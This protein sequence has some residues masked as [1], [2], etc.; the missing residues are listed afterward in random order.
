MTTDPH[1]SKRACIIGMFVLRPASVAWKEIDIQSSMYSD[2]LDW[3]YNLRGIDGGWLVANGSAVDAYRLAMQYALSD[4]VIM[5]SNNVSSEGVTVTAKDGT[6]KQGHLWQPYYPC[7]WGHLASSD[8][9]LLCR[10]EEQRC[11]WQKLGYLSDRKYPAQ[12]IFTVSGRKYPSAHDFL[13]ASI[14]T[15]RHPDGS[16]IEV[17]ILTSQ[18]G[19]IEIEQ[20]IMES[21]PHLACRIEKMLISI[22]PPHQDSSGTFLDECPPSDCSVLNSS[23][24]DLSTDINIALIPSILYKRFNMHIVNHDG[25]AEVLWRFFEAGACAQMNLTLCRQ[26]SLLEVLRE[27]PNVSESERQEAL[28]N[29]TERVQYFYQAARRDDNNVSSH[30]TTNSEPCSTSIPSY[31]KPLSVIVD[32]ADSVAVVTLIKSSMTDLASGVDSNIA[33]SAILSVAIPQNV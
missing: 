15:E 10:L 3:A 26:Q 7:S 16:E 14:F 24:K 4:A 20:R 27:N 29:F 31:M 9:E 30:G 28:S 8:P 5:S 12:I 33:A 18:A 1:K 21:F 11:E 22:P 2:S 23:P 6:R 17:Y 19:A 32:G 13:E 25:G